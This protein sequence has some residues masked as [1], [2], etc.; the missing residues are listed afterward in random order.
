MIGLY[1]AIFIL[2]NIGRINGQFDMMAF[3]I[4]VIFYV[5]PL[6]VWMYLAWKRPFIAGILLVVLAPLF[7]IFAGDTVVSMILYSLILML[8]GLL[9]IATRFT[10]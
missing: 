3:L 4:Y 8:P 6:V 10:A 9:L 5:P 2:A 1:G 7:G